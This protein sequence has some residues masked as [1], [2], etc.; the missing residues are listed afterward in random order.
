[1]KSN[2]F[3]TLKEMNPTSISRRCILSDDGIALSNF[4]KKSQ[5][6][7]SSKGSTFISFSTYSNIIDELFANSTSSMLIAINAL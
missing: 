6:F 2:S 7:Q 1:M 3:Q 4:R 5:A